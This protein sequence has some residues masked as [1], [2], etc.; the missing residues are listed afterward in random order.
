MLLNSV[1][2]N[3]LKY[4]ERQYKRPVATRELYAKIGCPSI[5]DYK[6]LVEN[7]LIDNCPVILQV[8]QVA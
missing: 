5:I 2:E 6:L 3:K 4:S 7:G 8:I 1:E